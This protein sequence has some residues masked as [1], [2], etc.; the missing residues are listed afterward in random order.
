MIFTDAKA[1]TVDIEVDDEKLTKELLSIPIEKW[2][3]GTDDY[4]GHYWKNIFLTKNSIKEFQDFK[5][6]K[7]ITHAQWYWD[8][9]LN[10]P[11]IKSL[12]KSLPIRT[13]GMVRAFIL[14]GPLVMHVDTDENTPKE[15]SYKMGLTI[16]SKLESAMIMPEITVKE[17]YIFFNDSVPHGF[18]DGRGEQISIRIFGEFDYEKFKVV[19]V[20]K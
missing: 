3:I 12:V 11:Y 19:R 10:I 16:A 17:K 1:V 4:S 20:Y 13:I 6:A 7:S 8:D 15:I 5:S 18:P 14:N 2:S 9:S